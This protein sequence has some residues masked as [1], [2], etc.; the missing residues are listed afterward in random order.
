MNRFWRI[1]AI[2]RKE[3]IDTLRDRR[4]LFAMI[5]VPIILYPAL[6]LGSLQAVD[7]QV[8][9][10]ER[11]QYTVAV[12]NAAVKHWLTHLVNTDAGRRHGPPTST[13][14]ATSEPS[15]KS[16]P[17]GPILTETSAGA[18]RTE[19]ALQDVAAQPP[20]FVIE[21]V[22]DVRAAVREG[23]YQAGI[24]IDG[25]PPA[26]DEPGSERVTVVFDDSEIR[27]KFAARGLQGVIDRYNASIV[28]QR[29]AERGLTE[30][31]LQPILQEEANVASAE[32]MAGSILGQI[33]PLILIIMTIT[34][35][36][37]PAIDLTAGERERG[38][39]ETLMV[40][41]VPTVDLIAG[42]FVVVAMIGMLS[43]T[44]NLLSVGGTIYLGGLGSML[45]QGQDFAVP[46]WTLPWVLLALVPMAVM[47][48][49]I[50]LA[51]CSFARSFK[52]A[53][54]YVMPV[55]IAALIPGVIGVLP[56][57][58]L[59]GPIRVIPVAN[60]VILTRELLLGRIDFEAIITVSLSTTL[61]AGA[62]VAIA[63]RLFGQEAVLFADSASIRTL[64]QRRFFTPRRVPAAS[65]A[66]LVLALMYSL[67]FFIQTS[68]QKR[69]EGFDFMVGVAIT[70]VLLLVIGPAFAAWYMRVDLRSAF[71]LRP[72]PLTGIIAATC[73]GL[74]TWILVRAW[75]AFQQSWLP[76]NPELMKAI[77]EQFAWLE[78]ASLPTILFFMAILPAIC[79]E[80]FFRGYVTSGLTGTLGKAGALLIVAAAFGLSHYNVH[81][82]IP[83]TMLGL[84]LGALAVQFRS[85]WPSMLA[86]AL[87]NGIS[88]LSERADGLKPVLDRL[89]F[90][91]DPNAITA[92]PNTWLFGAILLTLV[93][94][95]LC[96]LAQRRSQEFA[97][98]DDDA[99]A[100]PAAQP[101]AR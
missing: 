47:F 4:T 32:K 20:G 17:A 78:T 39:L 77:G 34:G 99:A 38:T 42:K 56:G 25:Q 58:Q 27:S 50:L 44:L 72:P 40:A 53:Q 67:N 6:M 51:V 10:L 75:L 9:R 74:S 100:A 15:A 26:P 64:L 84:L 91:S 54:N 93:G 24:V 18:D 2:W 12:N 85:I 86:H 69:L 31:F 82:L 16:Q 68:L 97:R 92:P 19:T 22:P 49:A 60:I 21:V 1:N 83:T 94:L 5:L 61:Y 55:M 3:L 79:E 30:S 29:L 98:D 71:L 88:A 7:V 37:Y 8:S 13:A 43:A 95:A 46:L 14:P 48:S 90:T 36:I 59:E 76:F 41:P 28:R 87:H 23:A 52:E 89:G 35:S 63:A 96:L 101:D 45:A 62:A 73:F 57:T 70:L 11:E 80:L 65:Q 81:R 66:L 33:V